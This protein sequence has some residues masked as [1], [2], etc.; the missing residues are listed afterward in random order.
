MINRGDKVYLCINA[1]G[2]FNGIPKRTNIWG[3]LVPA[4]G[5]PANIQFTTPGT[6]DDYVMELFWDM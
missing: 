1:S 5:S 4:Y 3:M 2:A 6:Y